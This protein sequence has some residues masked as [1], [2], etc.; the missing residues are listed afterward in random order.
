MGELIL[1]VGFSLVGTLIGFFTGLIP[2]IHVNNVAFTLLTLSPA[3]FR[4]I[5]GSPLPQGFLPLCVAS[6]VI[7][8][9]VAHTFLSF[10]PTAFFGAP[11]GDTAL[12]LLPAHHMLLEGR[13]YEAVSLSAVGSFCA[14]VSAFLLLLPFKFVF[15]APLHF[16]GILDAVLLFLLLGISALLILTE[17]FNERLMPMQ[18][19]LLA[20]LVFMLSGALGYSILNTELMNISNGLFNSYRVSLLFPALTGLFGVAS[21]LYSAAHAPDIPAQVLKEPEIDKSELTK[22]IAA[23]TLF[24]SVVGFLPGI[25]AAHATVFAMLARRNRAPEQIILTLSSVNTANAIFCTAALFLILKPRSGALIAVSELISVEPWGGIIPPLSLCYL[26]ISVLVASFFSYFATMLVGRRLS[27]IFTRLPYQLVVFGILTLL[28]ALVFLFNGVFG[29]LVMLVATC[30]G[31]V[32]IYLGVR[33]SHC[34]GV[35]LL[36]IILFYANISL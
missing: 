34:M 4:I 20:L 12:S 13:G 6:L 33:R 5:E 14:V 28:F 1:L 24:G 23:G 7:S 21:L 26:L 30:I 18:A 17:S 8:A 16:Y 25:T 2:G 27:A 36:P 29:M 32:P 9:S 15:S 31:L 10:I 19:V 35:L 22:S 11:E 3:I